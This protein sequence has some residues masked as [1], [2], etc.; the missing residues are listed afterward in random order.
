M[1]KSFI[2]KKFY[3]AILNFD[4]SDEAQDYFYSHMESGTGK[5]AKDGHEETVRDKILRIYATLF[6]EDTA[7]ANAPYADVDDVVNTADRLYIGSVGYD[8]DHWYRMKHHFPVIDD[9]NFDRFAALVIADM[10]MGPLH[11][12]AMNDG[13]T[14]VVGEADPLHMTA[15]QRKNQ[16]IKSVSII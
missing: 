6:C 12:A 15:E 4:D 2:D 1:G 14:L 8:S 5:V 9:D 7:M 10:N 16:K 11:D 13:D 3:D